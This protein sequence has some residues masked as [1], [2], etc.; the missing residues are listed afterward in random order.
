M[1]LVCFLFFFFLIPTVIGK[2]GFCA[3]KE[4]IST[5]MLNITPQ[6]PVLN[7][8]SIVPHDFPVSTYRSLAKVMPGKR[9]VK[10]T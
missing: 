4:A 9:L 6:S 3:K 8:T 7:T 1:S 10:K 2:L 5:H